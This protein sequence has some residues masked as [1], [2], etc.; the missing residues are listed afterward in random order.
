MA[1]A[2]EP[3]P[4]KTEGIE[5]DW[6]R[7]VVSLEVL[8]ASGTAPASIGTGFL[9]KTPN[10]HVLLVTAKHVV[11][12]ANGRVRRQLAYRINQAGSTSLLVSDGALPAVLGSWFLS[13]DSDVACRFLALGPTSEIALFDFGQFLKGALVRPGAPILVPGFPMGLR[14]EEYSTP[15][16][17]RGVVAR[18]AARELLIDAA[19]FPGNSGG[20]VFYVP[21]FKVA[22]PIQSYAISSNRVLGLVSEGISYV[23]TEVS[24]QT[25]KPRITFEQHAGLTKVVPGDGILALLTREDVA[26]LDAHLVGH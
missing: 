7:T 9:V 10:A 19:L 20:P 24:A 5:D 2:E 13:A 23:E 4:L 15:L 11:V 16:V 26:R 8:G 17:R 3:A 6:L 25:G 14:S 1:M 21:V 12:D 22:P 18:S